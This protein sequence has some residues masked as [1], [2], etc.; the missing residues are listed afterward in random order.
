MKSIKWIMGVVWL[1]GLTPAQDTPTPAERP[2]S[3][4]IAQT[5]VTTSRVSEVLGRELRNSQ[6]DSLGRVQELV[7]DDET[8]RLAYAILAP[9]AESP[10]ARYWVVPWDVLAPAPTV[11]GAGDRVERSFLLE[12]DKGALGRAPGFRRESW[13]VID[14]TYGK[15]VYAF[16]GRAPYWERE[17][18]ARRSAQDAA[19][20]RDDEVPRRPTAIDPNRTER[21]VPPVAREEGRELEQFPV[22]M[23]EPRNIKT[24]MGTITSLIEQTGRENDFGVGIRLLVNRDDQGT[25]DSDMLVFVGPSDFVKK[26]TFELKQNDRIALKGAEMERDGRKVFVATELTRGDKTMILRR[27]N[28]MPAWKRKIKVSEN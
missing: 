22:G 11:V 8:G 14:R 6:G 1:V 9:M 27:D 28:G 13:P 20:A 15:E 24:V 23:F 5:R 12:L 2:A 18:L 19:A 7:I 26:Q 4:P 21:D 3:R 17:R 16:Y 10:D 25:K